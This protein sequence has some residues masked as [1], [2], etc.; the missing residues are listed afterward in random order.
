ML[1]KI[2]KTSLVTA[3][4][5]FT[6]VSS[7]AQSFEN[8]SQLKVAGDS[9]TTTLDFLKI[10]DGPIMVGIETPTGDDRVFSSEGC[11]LRTFLAHAADD[12][13]V[14]A[15]L[16]EECQD[17]IPEFDARRQYAVAD[18]KDHMNLRFEPVLSRAATRTPVA[19]SRV[20]HDEQY[21]KLKDDVAFQS[22]KRVCSDS[23]NLYLSWDAR[24]CQ[25]GQLGPNCGCSEYRP[26]G[27]V[28]RSC[29]SVSDVLP[30][31]QFYGPYGQRCLDSSSS[32]RNVPNP[33]CEP[34]FTTRE[35]FAA[36]GTYVM[37]FKNT[38]HMK[39]F[40][41]NCGN[42]NLTIQWWAN[43]N[44]ELEFPNLGNTITVRPNRSYSLRLHAGSSNGRYRQWAFRY[45]VVGKKYNT[46]SAWLNLSG[47][48]VNECKVRI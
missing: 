30:I 48:P 29:L 7:Y 44:N 22:T 43:G 34:R 5:L 11:A 2:Y 4:L 47:S 28:T 41:Q 6:S 14:P 46:S 15:A 26:N 27:Q 42:E 13:V 24:G 19:C 8:I 16:A 17:E 18:L 23:C 9:G 36:R 31:A 21:D 12:E 20:K 33:S 45:K 1:R 38:S 10:K 3:C 25:L 32:C 35:K 40:V 37:R 39:A